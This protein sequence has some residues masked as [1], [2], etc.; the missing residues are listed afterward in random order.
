MVGF[1][2]VL[3]GMLRDGDAEFIRALARSDYGR[4]LLRRHKKDEYANPPICR[5]TPGSVTVPS[6][7]VNLVKE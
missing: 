1:G 5:L 2:D 4:P 6:D 3:A 7:F